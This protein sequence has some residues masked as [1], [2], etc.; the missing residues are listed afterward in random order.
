MDT[1]FGSLN[2]LAIVVCVVV[3]QAVLTIWF[4]ALFGVPWA[5]EYGA[6]DQ[7]Q[8][9]KAIPGYT[10]AIGAACVLLLSVGLATL[11]AKMGI[12]GAEQGIVFGLFVAL[13]FS[14][15]TA[16]PGYAF[17]RRYR[18]F[19]LAIGSQTLLIVV[20]SVILALW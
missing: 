18:A 7:K 17:L 5:K 6:A 19:A 2:W 13:H 11:Q 16:L 1:D 15:A 14:I 10:Y 12:E 4:V 3:G 20:L 9:T 8:H